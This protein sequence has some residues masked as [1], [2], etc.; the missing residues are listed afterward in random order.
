MAE[1]VMQKMNDAFGMDFSN[2]V[3]YESP[4]VEEMGAEAASMGGMITFAPGKYRPDSTTGQALLGHEL[5]HVAQQASGM[6]SGTGFLN[7]PALESQ[8]DMQ[9]RAAALGQSVSLPGPAAVPAMSPGTA[10]PVQAKKPDR[11]KAAAR[12]QQ[13]AQAPAPERPAEEVFEENYP[14]IAQEL[15]ARGSNPNVQGGATYHDRF[16]NT[17]LAMGWRGKDNSKAQADKA[18]TKMYGLSDKVKQRLA[19][20]GITK[21]SFSRYYNAPRETTGGWG[22]LTKEEM[23]GMPEYARDVG[24]MN[25]IESE[26]IGEMLDDS[27]M[28]KLLR[29]KY[30]GFSGLSQEAREAMGGEY[31]VLGALLNDIQLRMVGPALATQPGMTL[32]AQ[33]SM[34]LDNGTINS[35]LDKAAGRDFNALSDVELAEAAAQINDKET[36]MKSPSG[37]KPAVPY[38]NVARLKQYIGLLNKMRGVVT[39]PE[40]EPQPQA[41]QAPQYPT[42]RSVDELQFEEG[43][44]SRPA[45]ATMAA[46]EE[47]TPQSSYDEALSVIYHR[48]KNPNPANLRRT[49]APGN[50]P[51]R[52]CA[53]GRWRRSSRARRRKRRTRSG[54]SSGDSRNGTRMNME[55]VFNGI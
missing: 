48:I 16:T 29:A 28:Q 9:G 37:T 32:V 35:L 31:G 39:A 54:G 20:R 42:V 17:L 26:I 45:Y 33:G 23:A 24:T 5:A 51:S 55:G 36:N 34:S 12:P 52:S 18:F 50:A 47:V 4:I 7:D 2:V 10:A 13:A 41:P 38:T 22:R 46:P 1:P 19:D 15:Q 53:P 43:T 11:K 6:V 40:P 27:N 3:I 30:K 44:H 25:D 21:E 14:N 49:S 8:A